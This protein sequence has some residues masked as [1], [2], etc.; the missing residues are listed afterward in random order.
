LFNSGGTVGLPVTWKE[1]KAT[2]K[3]TGN[4]IQWATSSEKNTK[5][6]VVEYSYD[7]KNFMTASRDIKA[8]GNST[9]SNSYEYTHLEEFG[10]MVYYRIKQIDRDGKI[11]YSKIV[12]VKR[13]SKLPEFKVSMYP[14]PLN[15]NELNLKI[16][17]VQKSLA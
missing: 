8:A 1:V 16:Q 11:D 17:T 10:E 4:L 3:E 5:S 7:A 13:M 6:F 14:I 9:T 12:N 2:A 15:T